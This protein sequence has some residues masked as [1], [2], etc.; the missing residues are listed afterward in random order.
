MK[1]LYFS[2]HS[3]GLLSIALTILFP[4]TSKNSAGFVK[5]SSGIVGMTFAVVEDMFDSL[6]SKKMLLR[7]EC[8][9][10]DESGSQRNGKEDLETFP[11]TLINPSISSDL[12]SLAYDC[13]MTHLII[14]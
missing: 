5:A 1:V 11:Q 10:G 13:D 3:L 12:R 9:V 4:V 8:A 7:A 6:E 14:L 2:S